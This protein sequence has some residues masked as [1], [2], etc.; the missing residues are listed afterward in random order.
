VEKIVKEVFESDPMSY[1][2]AHEDLVNLYMNYKDSEIYKELV[3]FL[4]DYNQDWRENR[5]LGY[6]A[7]EFCLHIIGLCQNGFEDETGSFKSRL[8]NLYETIGEAYEHFKAFNRNVQM[9]KPNPD[10]AFVWVYF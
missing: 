6:Y 7:A 5:E 9:G 1:S 10:M 4:N 2:T 3:L 8:Q